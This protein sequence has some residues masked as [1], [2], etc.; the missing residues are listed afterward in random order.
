MAVA[1]QQDLDPRLRE[2]RLLGQLVRMVPTRRRRKPRTS[3][4]P[5]RLPGRSSAVTKRP[6]PSNT[7]IGWNP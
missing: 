6:S 5:G 3:T 7:T 4:P 1:A 2:G